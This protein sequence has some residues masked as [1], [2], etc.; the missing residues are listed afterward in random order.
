MQT[1]VAFFLKRT[2]EK[3]RLGVDLQWTKDGENTSDK[4]VERNSLAMGIAAAI[5]TR[6]AKGD[7]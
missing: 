6:V 3:T 5:L 2:M 4:H 1:T 7:L